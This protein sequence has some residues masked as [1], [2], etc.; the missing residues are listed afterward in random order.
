MRR[1]HSSLR[2]TRKQRG[3]SCMTGFG[4][5]LDQHKD[6]FICPIRKKRV[7]G[8]HLNDS[9]KLPLLHEKTFLVRIPVKTD[10]FY[11]KIRQ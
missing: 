11:N 2:H 10:S 3:K 5:L 9:I 1:V 6:N 8:L 7:K 4:D